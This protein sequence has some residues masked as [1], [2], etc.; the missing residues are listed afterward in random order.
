MNSLLKVVGD[1][2]VLAVTHLDLH[3]ARALHN[4]FTREVSLA[5]V[6]MFAE[7]SLTVDC[8]HV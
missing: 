6:G 1:L 3:Q 5:R 4:R 8:H 2:S 7:F